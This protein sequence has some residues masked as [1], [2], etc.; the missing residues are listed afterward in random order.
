MRRR[1]QVP[2]ETKDKTIAEVS[3]EQVSTLEEEDA[4]RQRGEIGRAHV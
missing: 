1:E 2:R 4:P 3:V